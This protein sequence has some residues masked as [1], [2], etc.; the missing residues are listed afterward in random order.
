MP[1]SLL[2]SIKIKYVFALIVLAGVSLGS[3]LLFQ[4]YETHEKTTANEINTS[5]RQ[6]MISQRLAIL[7]LQMD[8]LE[9]SKK[10]QDIRLEFQNLIETFKRNHKALTIGDPILGISPPRSEAIKSIYFS[11]PINLDILV[12]DLIHSAEHLL[13]EHDAQSPSRLDDVNHNHIPQFLALSDAK[14]LS[15]LDFVVTQY[16]LDA[17]KRLD[18]FHIYSV[19]LLVLSLIFIGFSWVGIFRPLSQKLCNYIE[20]I[21]DCATDLEVAKKEAEHANQVKAN[22]LSSMS[23]ELRTPLNSIFGFTQLLEMNKKTTLTPN[24]SKQV[25][26]I[27]MAGDH[28]LHIIDDI[29]E[30]SKIEAGKFHVDIHPISPQEIFTECLTYTNNAAQQQNI[31]VKMEENGPFPMIMADATRLRQITLNFISNA[32]KYN[33]PEG[34]VTLSTELLNEHLRVSVRDTGFG[35]PKD[36][37]NEIFQPFNRLG[38]E[39]SNVKGNGIGLVITKKLI[40]R[41]NGDIGFES[42]PDMGSTF[43]FDLPLQTLSR[44]TSTQ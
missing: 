1:H 33:R 13:L 7:G 2:L 20:Q 9:E 8:R 12:K 29:L 42:T 24:Q 21:T 23:H 27:K 35:I 17:E 41:M 31:I 37:Q 34:K 16:Q 15:A 38:A 25:H 18:N 36:K 5:G 40:E 10:R 11:S 22:F 28:L 4:I 30:F 19:I 39:T 32:I 44:N 6:R 14:F 26:Q 3:F 43:W